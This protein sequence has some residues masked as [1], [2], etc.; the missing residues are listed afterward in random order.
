VSG[1]TFLYLGRQY[2]LRVEALAES[3]EDARLRS[4]WLVVGLPA[5]MP[6]LQLADRPGVFTVGRLRG[7]P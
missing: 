4:G 7:G 6:E 3:G 5:G 1:E 2:R